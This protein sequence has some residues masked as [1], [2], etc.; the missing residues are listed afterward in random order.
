MCKLCTPPDS[1]PCGKSLTYSAVTLMLSSCLLPP[2]FL[3]H[4]QQCQPTNASFRFLGTRQIDASP[5]L[6]PQQCEGMTKTHHH[7]S[8]TCTSRVCAPGIEVMCRW[9]CLGLF[10]TQGKAQEVG[11]PPGESCILFRTLLLLTIHAITSKN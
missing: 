8:N 6:H 11:D 5:S 2:T 1:H 9:T 4:T 10:R 3:T 7:K